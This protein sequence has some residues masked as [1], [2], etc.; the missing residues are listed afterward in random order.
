MCYI[1]FYILSQFHFLY[2]NTLRKH[3]RVNK[4]E[5]VHRYAVREEKRKRKRERDWEREI[6][7]KTENYR[8]RER[9][10]ERDKEIYKYKHRPING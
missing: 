7:K 2:A 3:L 6:K 4:N 1:L 8:Q 9:D 5:I 10:A